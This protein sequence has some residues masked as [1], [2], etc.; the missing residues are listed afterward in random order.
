MIQHK[1]NRWVG[2]NICVLFWSNFDLFPF[3]ESEVNSAGSSA[4]SKL[5]SGLS[6]AVSSLA[7]KLSRTKV[8]DD[9]NETSNQKKIGNIS[10]ARQQPPAASDDNSHKNISSF[11]SSAV[12]E[13]KKEW[14]DQ[15]SNASS[16]NESVAEV[17]A[18]NGW[19]DNWDEDFF[20]E[21]E[22]DPVKVPEEKTTKTDTNKNAWDMDDADDWDNF[23]SAKPEVVS[24]PTTIT[25]RR[26]TGN[27]PNPTA[28]S[29]TTKRGPMRLGAQK[30]NK[31]NIDWFVIYT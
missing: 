20:A 7:A 3:A 10:L 13:E 21:A 25:E 11:S 17:P 31:N 15:S 27:R 1:S 30:L 29:T 16:R 2:L 8:E 12:I 26:T 18:E 22:K 19:N 23:G 4:S 6:W 28:K 24:R 14:T 9:N 5:T